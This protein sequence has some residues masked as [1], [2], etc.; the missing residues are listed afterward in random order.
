MDPV[1]G[2]A[3]IGAGVK[4]VTS[5]AGYGKGKKAQKAQKEAQKIQWEEAIRTHQVNIDLAKHQAGVD[6]FGLQSEGAQFARGQMAAMGAA[7][8]EV[9][10][11]TPLMNMLQTQAGIARDVLNVQKA[12]DIE[13]EY[14][15]EEIAQLEKNLNPGMATSMYG[16]YGDAG[17]KP[18]TSLAKKNFKTGWGAK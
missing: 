3:V 16:M 17:Q 2:S 15:E 11:G 1:I 13:V 8:A 4:T 7:G 9:G 14:R 10:S 18:M 12:L 5:V 6:I